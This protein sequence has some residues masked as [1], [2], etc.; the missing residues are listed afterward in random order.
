VHERLE[1]LLKRVDREF[2]ESAT[3]NESQEFKPVIKEVNP[4]NEEWV[5]QTVPAPKGTKSDTHILTT[6]KPNLVDSNGYENR[7][8]G[9]A[10]DEHAPSS[11]CE[12]SK[13]KENQV[14]CNV[15]EKSSKKGITLKTMMHACP[16]FA[17]TGRS[18]CGYMKDWNDAHR[19]ASKIA[20][21]VGI[22]EEAWNKAQLILGPAVAS[23]VIALI[24]D[25]HA[26]GDVRSP[27]GYLR[28]IVE[29]ARKGELNIERS[30]YGRLKSQAA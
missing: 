13:P 30:F 20:S 27:G 4:A 19:A 5:Q 15:R 12:E 28:G 29:K 16:E 11:C 26:A 3:V 21:F 1:D 25:K 2:E 23:A 10:G 6:N 22:S 9:R 8:A 17:E 18:V 7:N 24:F 14:R